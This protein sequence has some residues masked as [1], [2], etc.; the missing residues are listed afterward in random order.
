MSK[1]SHN[2]KRNVGIIYSLLLKTAAAGLVEGDISKQKKARI[3]LKRFFSPGTELHREWKLFS[4][5]SEPYGADGSLATRILGEAKIAAGRH[6][7]HI[8]QREKNKCIK[9]VNYSFGPTFWKQHIDSYT[10]LATIGQLLESWRSPAD[11]RDISKT[12]KY[13]AVVHGILKEVKQVKTLEEERVPEADTLVVKLMI[14]KF[15]K[16]YSKTMTL[17]QQKL[18]KSY[19]FSDGDSSSFIKLV[20]A[21]QSKAVNSLDE[22]KYQC[23]N[24]IVLSK[25]DE[26]RSQIMEV[27]ASDISDDNLAKFLKIVDLTEEIR[28]GK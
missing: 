13:E 26:V 28:S 18:I 14:E 7:K 21:V 17:L 27:N 15:N 20:E 16:K 2:K 8:L 10:K 12:T 24:D 5:L 4:A 23:S 9:D 19:I 22:Y 3:I 6:N 11:Q 1:K 25:I